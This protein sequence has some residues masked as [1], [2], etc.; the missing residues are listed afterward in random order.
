[1]QQIRIEKDDCQIMKNP[2]QN[3]QW[4]SL[5][6]KTYAKKFLAIIQQSNMPA[7]KYI[8]ALEYINQMIPWFGPNAREYSVEELNERVISVNLRVAKNIEYVKNGGDTLSTM[9][10]IKEMVR[11]AERSATYKIEMR[12]GKQQQRARQWGQG[13]EKEAIKRWQKEWETTNQQ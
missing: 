9:D 12:K 2:Q 6:L 3:K 13:Q 7:A 1:M 4:V 11:K 10:E 8:D 5:A